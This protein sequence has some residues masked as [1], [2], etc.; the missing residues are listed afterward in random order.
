ME[1]ISVHTYSR[2]VDLEKYKI[3][4]EVILPISCITKISDGQLFIVEFS[5]EDQKRFNIGLSG[6]LITTSKEHGNI[7]VCESL[8]AIKQK[9]N[10]GQENRVL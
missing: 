7:V 4:N 1:F 10:S 9:I 3:N 8:D 2:D 6:T 5:E